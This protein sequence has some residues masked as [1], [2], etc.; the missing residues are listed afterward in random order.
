MKTTPSEALEV[1]L[2]Q[3]LLDLAAI[4]V[5]GLSAYRL[6]CLG[7]WRDTGQGHTKLNFLWKY[8]FTLNQARVLKKYQLVKPFKIWIPTRQ[9]WQKPDKNIDPN[10]HLCFTDGSRIRDCFGAGTTHT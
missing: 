10:L 8:S 9:H 3:M 7:E 1:A 6:K 4:V 2:C 5:A